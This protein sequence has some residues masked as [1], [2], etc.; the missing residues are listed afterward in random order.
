MQKCNCNHTDQYF[1]RTNRA[2]V[3]LKIY[4]TTLSLGW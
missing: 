2:V 4:T 3:Y 1:K